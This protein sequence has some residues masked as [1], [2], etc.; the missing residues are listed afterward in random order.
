MQESEPESP[1]PSEGATATAVV[2]E[3]NKEEADY[4]QQKLSELANLKAQFKRVQEMTDSTKLIEQHLSSMESKSSTV[5]QSRQ[6]KSVQSSS[7]TSSSSTSSSRSQMSSET[8]T[9]EEAVT[10][11][12]RGTPDNAELLNA[13][14]NMV[15]DFTSDLRGQEESLRAERLRI[16]SIKEEIIQRKESK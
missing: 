16:K 15:T 9:S 13:M 4:L 10:S 11:G 3:E 5:V 2:E 14:I 7:T 6:V 8:A 12:E 1:S